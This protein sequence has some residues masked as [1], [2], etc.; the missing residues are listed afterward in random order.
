MNAL[1]GKLAKLAN[2][3]AEFPFAAR[4]L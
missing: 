3:D 1:F 2:A 4:H